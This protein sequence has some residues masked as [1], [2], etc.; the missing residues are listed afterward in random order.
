MF[1]QRLLLTKYLLSGYHVLST[2]EQKKIPASG[3]LTFQWGN[4]QNEHLAGHYND[5][6]LNTV[7]WKTVEGFEQMNNTFHLLQLLYGE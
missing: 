2:E 5:W 3:E 1:I 7:K 4:N 6:L